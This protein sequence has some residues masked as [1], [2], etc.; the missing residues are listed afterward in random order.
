MLVVN[1]TRFMFIYR[2]RDQD[3]TLITMLENFVTKSWFLT[4]RSEIPY[5]PALS[6]SQNGKGQNDINS[7]VNVNCPKEPIL[8][9]SPDTEVLL[10]LSLPMCPISKPSRFYSRFHSSFGYPSLALPQTC[11]LNLFDMSS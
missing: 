2:S 4:R 5:K 1:L 7:C 11:P 8:F 9:S 3:R 10:S 6:R